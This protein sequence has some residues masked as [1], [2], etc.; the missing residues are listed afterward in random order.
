MSST[1][2]CENKVSH[3]PQNDY[4]VKNPV[5]HQHAYESSSADY[6]E[7][8]HTGAKRDIVLEPNERMTKRIRFS[9]EM[10]YLAHLINTKSTLPDGGWRTTS[11]PRI[12]ISGVQL[13]TAE[14]SS[15]PFQNWHAPQRKSKFLKYDLLMNADCFYRKLVKETSPSYKGSKTATLIEDDEVS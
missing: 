8:I 2:L 10:D 1:I 9:D 5:I 6:L 7:T 11:R 15:S 14:K 12:D 3:Q 13:I 4:S